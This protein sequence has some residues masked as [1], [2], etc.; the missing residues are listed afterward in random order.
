MSQR[1][2]RPRPTAAADAADAAPSSTRRLLLVLA[3]GNFALGTGAFVLPAV[4]APLA[5]DL[6]TSLAAAGW[7][8]SGYALTYAVA[9][10]LLAALTGSWPRRRVL[11]LGL[12]LVATGNAGL[13]LAPG[14][15]AAHAGRAVSALGGALYTPV[16]AS[17]AAATA[18][19]ERRGAAL[20]LVFAGMTVAQVLGIPLGAL[21][22]GGVG[23]RA[24]FLG[25]TAAAL[26]A[27]PV[28]A[29]GVPAAV[30]VAAA[31]LGQ[32]GRLLRDPGAALALS[33]TVA[34]FAGQFVVITFL[35]PV[36]ARA[37]GASGSALAFYLWLFGLAGV[38]ANLL[39]GALADR[40]GPVR[41][42]VGL[43]AVSAVAL[44]ILP[45][46]EARPS[47][48]GFALVL[49][50]LSGYAFMT[51]Q[52]ARLV[53]LMPASQGLALSLNAAALYAGSALGG[54]AGSALV[55]ADG[56]GALGPGASLLLA[57]ALLLLAASAR[58]PPRPG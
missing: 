24:V 16:A 57:V 11:L 13:A 35:G 6:G 21:L 37:T 34:F 17:I 42:I 39:G 22:A 28:V 20:A 7:L 10:P 53:A 51:P 4:L 2:A 29:R 18:A 33:V 58:L 43:T 49:W 50:G 54:A 14:L 30:P 3:L 32:L 38:A 9:S 5:A 48:A 52:Q 56:L 45:A 31:T 46:L 40:I 23:W 15:P 25:V 19:P 44:L 26:A 55:A 47:A 1:A 27:L 36:I 41:T 8:M 12:L